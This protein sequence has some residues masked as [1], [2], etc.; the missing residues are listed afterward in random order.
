MK[1]K[2]IIIGKK[3]FIGSNL[4]KYLKLNNYVKILNLNEFIKKKESYIKKFNYVI[5]CTLNKSYIN[6][7][8]KLKND[9]NLI[10]ANKIK[11]LNICYI[12]LSSRKVYQPKYNIIETSKVN[13]KCNYSFNK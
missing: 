1:I 10:I 12:F 9:F 11:L 3:S 6:K 2:L 4:Y 5:N 7:K 13:P 8:Y